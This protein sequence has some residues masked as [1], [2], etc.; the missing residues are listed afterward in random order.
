MTSGR[1]TDSGPGL[2]P[3]PDKDMT[4]AMTTNDPQEV[5]ASTTNDQHGEWNLSDTKGETVHGSN[6]MPGM[7][8]GGEAGYV[9]NDPQAAYGGESEITDADRDRNWR[10]YYETKLASGELIVKREL[11]EWLESEIALHTPARVMSS[12]YKREAMQSVLDHLNKKT[13]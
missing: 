6:P 13:S 12:V 10:S 5:A 11:T 7:F 2:G 4:H 3:H 8:P 9:T 1:P